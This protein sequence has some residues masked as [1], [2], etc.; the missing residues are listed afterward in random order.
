MSG[1][2]GKTPPA[3]LRV[4]LVA[5]ADD[6]GLGHMTWEFARAIRPERTL[7]VDLGRASH[8]ANR[9]DRYERPLVARWDADSRLFADPE[10]VAKWVD[11]LDIIYSAETFYDWRL[12]GWARDRGVATVLHAMPELLPA[13]LPMTPTQV[14]TPTS[15]RLQDLPAETL[16]V[17]VP[18]ATD[19]FGDFRSS[20]EPDPRDRL[21]VLHVAGRRA[22][23]DR[24]GTLSLYQA[25]RQITADVEITITTQ[26]ARLPHPTGRP[27]NVQLS[28]VAGNDAPR[29]Y[30]RLYDGHD[31]LVMPRKYGGLCLPVQE[32][33]AAG[34]AIVMTNAA[35]NDEY[36]ATLVDVR[37]G[38][39]IDTPAGHVPM[40]DV[41]VRALASTIDL[42]A[43]DPSVLADARSDALR[44]ATR[45]SWDVLAPTYR[46]LMAGAVRAFWGVS[47]DVAG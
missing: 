26:D 25:M 19:R 39:T 24:N 29:E 32:A 44:W 16:V 11:G 4:G 27:R 22:A 12:V 40:F 46:D 34:L 14:W 5:R 33:A 21:R 30:W 42:M 13:V 35:P 31:V 43:T 15:W 47:R 7:V 45:R 6:R 10:A 2:R 23:A 41:D 3:D 28:A 36:P 37:A 8:F 9:L 18:V 20:C 17:P 38:G 1:R